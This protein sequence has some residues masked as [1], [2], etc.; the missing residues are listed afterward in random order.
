MSAKREVA[1]EKARVARDL[2][3]SN[4]LTPELSAEL[5]A[6]RRIGLL[7]LGSPHRMLAE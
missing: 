2:I 4:L 1:C 7:I 3:K 6:Q 5:F